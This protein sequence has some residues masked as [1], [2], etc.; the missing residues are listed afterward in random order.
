[1][2]IRPFR[3]PYAG[4]SIGVRSRTQ[5]HLPWPSPP[6]HG[7]GSL[8]RNNDAAGFT[9]RYGPASRIHPAPTPASQPKLGA[10][11]PG[12][13]ASPRTGLTPASHRELTVKLRHNNHLRLPWRPNFWTHTQGSRPHIAPSAAHRTPEHDRRSHHVQFLGSNK[14][15]LYDSVT[16]PSYLRIHPVERTERRERN[17]T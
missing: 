7:L 16:P 4:G 15:S 10:S 17:G 8:T 3:A 1:M 6:G 5:E 11:L 12:T 9:S 13:L 14:R 2:T